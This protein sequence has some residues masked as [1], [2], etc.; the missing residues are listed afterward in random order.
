[1]TTMRLATTIIMVLGLS[2]AARPAIGSEPGEFTGIE[3][4]TISDFFGPLPLRWSED[5]YEL[6]IGLSWDLET[7]SLLLQ[8]EPAPPHSRDF[9]SLWKPIRI[10]HDLELGSECPM[11]KIFEQMFGNG[12]RAFFFIGPIGTRTALFLDYTYPS[13]GADFV[14]AWGF[15]LGLRFPGI[16]GSRFTGVDLYLGLPF[17]DK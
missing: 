2:L 11:E 9:G 17:P 14:P 3:F 6:G 13:K 15:G 1:M 5:S 8:L 10:K 7:D 12:L 4:P 16:S